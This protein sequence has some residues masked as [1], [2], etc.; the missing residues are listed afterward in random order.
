MAVFEFGQIAKILVD[1]IWQLC[2]SESQGGNLTVSSFETKESDPDT[3]FTYISSSEA[4]SGWTACNFLKL[5]LSPPHKL[6]SEELNLYR[7]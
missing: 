3:E 2:D 7:K 4:V 6:S 5:L 1:D